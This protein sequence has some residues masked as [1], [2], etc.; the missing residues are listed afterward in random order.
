VTVESLKAELG[1]KPDPMDL[2]EAMELLETAWYE[3]AWTAMDDGRLPEAAR[4]LVRSAHAL[5]V[6]KPDGAH[7][8]DAQFMGWLRGAATAV[9]EAAGVALAGD[10][11]Q[12]KA[13]LPTIDEKRCVA[14]HRVYKKE[15]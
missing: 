15:K 7:A 10:A 4:H 2:D 8:A 6:A 5:A 14:C 12:L 13:L 11:Q 9:E 3:E 1:L